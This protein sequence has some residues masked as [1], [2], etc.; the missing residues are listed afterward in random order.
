MA[1]FTGIIAAVLTCAF[2]ATVS[3]EIVKV[4]S[5]AASVYLNDKWV[6]LKAEGKSFFVY[7]ARQGMYLIEVT[8]KGE[9]KYVW[10]RA[11]DVALDWGKSTVT[12]ATVAK[13]QDVNTLQLSDGTCVQFRRIDVPPDDTPLTRQT[14]AWLKQV[15]EGKSVTL[16]FETTGSNSLGY[17]EAYVYVDGAFLNRI[18]LGSGLARVSASLRDKGRYDT[19]LEYYADKAREAGIGIWK[20]PEKPGASGSEGA[21]DTAAST[22]TEASTEPVRLTQAQLNQWAIRLQ[23]EVKVVSER[24]AWSS[25]A[26]DGICLGDPEPRPAVHDGIVPAG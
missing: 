11:Q 25:P 22:G 21:P 7:D 17:R 1:R 16:E 4:T 20:V 3:A 23:V 10:I 6:T 13:V 9:K 8:V 14:Y 15:L 12:T 5:P 18:L 19:V 26:Q 2:V 24:L